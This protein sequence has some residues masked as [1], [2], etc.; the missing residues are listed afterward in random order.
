M[1]KQIL[2]NLSNNTKFLLQRLPYNEAFLREVMR[3]QTL[4]PLAVVHRATEDTELNGYFIPKVSSDIN[5]CKA[6]T[7]IRDALFNIQ[8]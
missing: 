8:Q 1:F 5:L 4:V 2:L 6:H 7:I 3:K